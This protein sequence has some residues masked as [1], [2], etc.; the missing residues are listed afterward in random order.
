MCSVGLSLSF[1]DPFS[2]LSFTLVY[3]L[4]KSLSASI[5]FPLLLPCAQ[6][7][8]K[9]FL[10]D[11]VVLEWRSKMIRMSTH[12]MH[13]AVMLDF[14]YDT[15]IY[16]KRSLG[17]GIIVIMSATGVAEKNIERSFPP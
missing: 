3:F 9:L 15:L 7:K 13:I 1:C 8:G 2:S 12:Y 16:N 11:D 5:V 6:M 10:C 17:F 14:P 4:S